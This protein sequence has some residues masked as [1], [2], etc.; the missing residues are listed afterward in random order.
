MTS[1]RKSREALA[2]AASILEA[3]LGV[4]TGSSSV[5][6][7]PMVAVVGCVGARRYRARRVLKVGGYSL[8]GREDG[9]MSFL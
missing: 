7:L 1:D 8:K 5:G 4:R 9:C 2:S 6:M 3:I